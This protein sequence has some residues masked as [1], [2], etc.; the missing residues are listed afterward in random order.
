MKTSFL[1]P[2]F[3]LFL[4]VFFSCG[5]RKSVQN[6]AYKDYKLIGMVDKVELWGGDGLSYNT[7]IWI[8]KAKSSME[9][10][11]A[12]YAYLNTKYGS[13]DEG[14]IFMGQSLRS[15]NGRYFDVLKIKTLPDST[16]IDVYFDINDFFGKY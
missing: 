7:A 4:F 14:H 13:R 6:S 2:I 10:I 11:P 3:V 12:E 15:N 5:S 16:S 9:G 8:K 1:K